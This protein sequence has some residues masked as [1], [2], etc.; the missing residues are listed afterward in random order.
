MSVCVHGRRKV[1]DGFGW[2]LIAWIVLTGYSCIWLY[3]VGLRIRIRIRNFYFQCSKCLHYY[4]DRTEANE[5]QKSSTQFSKNCEEGL[6]L[7]RDLFL[8]M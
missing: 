1:R 4:K 3:F 6:S 7:S 2:F 5:E 8:K